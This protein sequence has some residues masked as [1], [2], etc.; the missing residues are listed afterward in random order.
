MSLPNKYLKMEERKEGG[1]KKKERG[2]E[3]GRWEG[4]KMDGRISVCIG[5]STSVMADL[6]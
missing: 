3:E 4:G 5:T 6:M 1:K 2:T